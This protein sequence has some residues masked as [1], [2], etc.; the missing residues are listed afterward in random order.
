MHTRIC[1][2]LCLA[3]LFALVPIAVN[4]QAIWHEGAITKAPWKDTRIHVGIDN[5]EYTF[6]SEGIHMS[7]NVE[8]KRGMYTEEPV[9]LKDL[10]SGQ[11]VMIRAQGHRI[12]E[13][14]VMEDR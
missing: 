10:A 7:R 12:Y 4:A 6:I 11:R 3:V 2:I 8:V 13:I 5:V 14:H 9:G 1:A